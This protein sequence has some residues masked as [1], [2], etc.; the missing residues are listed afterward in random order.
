MRH[1]EQCFGTLHLAAFGQ[2]KTGSQRGGADLPQRN[3]HPS[4]SE[5]TSTKIDRAQSSLC[6][7]VTVGP[8][9]I[10]V[11]IEVGLETNSGA[12]K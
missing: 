11:S 1:A 10:L 8:A 6:R 3:P 2:M 5:D 12:V 7:E 4:F 9:A